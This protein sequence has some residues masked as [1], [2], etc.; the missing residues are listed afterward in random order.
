L[1]W[2]FWLVV[3]AALGLG[4]FV[5]G[6]TGMGL[7]LVSV[8]ALAAFLGVPHTLAIL[9]VPLIVTNGWQVWRFFPNRHGTG[10]LV[11]LL[12]AGA[13][14]IVIGTW[15]LTALPVR[16]LSLVL[17]ALVV[18][19]IA[20]LL[21]RPQLRL[22]P[23]TGLTLSPA[24]GLVSGVLQ[25]ATGIS[26]P[27]SITFIHALGLTPRGF[28]FAVSAMFLLFSTAQLAAL[29]V[30]GIMT[31]GRFLEGWVAL[32]PVVLMMPVGAWA[33]S[34]LSRQTFDRLI[35]GLLAALACKLIVDA[36]S[37]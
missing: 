21:A 1:D 27:T 12:P 24:V 22:S 11:R 32:I 20:L 6:A 37:G 31:W 7:P 3:I 5:K 25:A 13:I 23:E 9:T 2:D 8:P 35:L 29:A 33:A 14:G 34:L 16:A 4:G 28:V 15:A 19:Y 30:A 17:A 36:L 26:A 10:F 18:S